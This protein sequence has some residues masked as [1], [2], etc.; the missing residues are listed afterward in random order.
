MR[1]MRIR[2]IVVGLLAAAGVA[3]AAGD[4]RGWSEG[5][6]AEKAPEVMARK[7]LGAIELPADFQKTI[8]RPT[9]LVY[10]SPTC[11]HCRQVAPELAALSGKLRKKAD[12]VM[13]ATPSASK[14]ALD[15]WKDSFSGRYRI[16][17]D[18]DRSIG[19]AMA[20][21]STPA[22]MLVEPGDGPLAILDAYYPYAPGYAG[23]VEMRLADTP[24]A[25]FA[26]DTY[27]GV[28]TC[29][30]C[31]T[32]EA[33]S[34]AISHHA[35]AWRTLVIRDKHTE[36]EC[37]GCH[38]TGNG[39]PT[40]W[41]GQPD[42][43]L[44]SVGCEACHGP[45]GPHDGRA[46]EPKDT[47]EGCHDDKHSIAFSYEK[48]LPH[49]DHYKANGMDDD[50]FR[51]A[52]TAL[53]NGTAPRP[54][55]AFGE[56]ENVGSE[57]CKDCHEDEHAQWSASPHASAMA[58]LEGESA[59]DPGC[60]HCHA[61][62]PTPGP[63]TGSLEGYHL[64]ESVGCE[65]CHGPGEAH[66]AAGGGTDNIEGLGEDCPVC[67]IEAICTSCH[68]PQWDDSWDLDLKLPKVGHGG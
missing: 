29:A 68:T 37:T 27:Q 63:P 42:S 31:H 26:P 48:G 16:V 1:G 30:V 58:R 50:A 20:I 52:L 38:V 5:Q 54:L 14:E 7:P 32:Q 39:E 67:V 22:V 36:A 33:E 17:H 53:G 35:I 55:L 28:T 24:F 21:R 51:E 2:W 4:P 25:A 19:T 45:G 23:L 3:T 56:G 61:T 59:S 64:E 46:T 18:E 10:F 44:T 49:I 47:C 34:W 8:K 65:T 60:V 6:P 12:M 9:V 66:V 11:P 57:A 41:D 13:I 40:G 15:E 43:T 62:P